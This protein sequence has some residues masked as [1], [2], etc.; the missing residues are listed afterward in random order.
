MNEF[1]PADPQRNTFNLKVAKTRPLKLRGVGPVRLAFNGRTIK[2]PF[3]F[4]FTA[5]FFAPLFFIISHNFP[6]VNR[7]F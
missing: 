7:V 4:V 5:R 1:V 6:F 2:T 3:R